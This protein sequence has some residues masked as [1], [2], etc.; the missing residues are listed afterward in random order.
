MSE[1]SPL[2]ILQIVRTQ[3]HLNPLTL[4]ID[5]IYGPQ[6]VGY[7]DVANP[8][9]I[10][11]GHFLTK[12]QKYA[13]EQR[14]KFHH[15]INGR[16][17]EHFIWLQREGAPYLPKLQR[18]IQSYAAELADPFNYPE[19]AEDTRQSV[20]ENFKSAASFIDHHIVKD[21]VDAQE[22]ASHDTEQ[23]LALRAFLLPAI[24]AARKQLTQRLDDLQKLHPESLSE[25]SDE[26]VEQFRLVSA[27][28]RPLAQICESLQPTSDARLHAI[29][30]AGAG[31]REAMSL[32]LL[33]Q[34]ING[35]DE[36][37]A[38]PLQDSASSLRAAFQEAARIFPPR[39]MARG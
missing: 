38:A 36:A 12:A 15:D 37:T 25:R 4:Y 5:A 17:L 30:F 29:T 35:M 33:R 19:M 28:Y 20:V 27:A 26:V 22:P 8:Q 23:K 13:F 3:L 18:T 24:E 2:H 34:V 39:D 1:L 14:Y 21:R 9:D 31:G 10:P 7:R 6:A 32:Q 11:K 16:L